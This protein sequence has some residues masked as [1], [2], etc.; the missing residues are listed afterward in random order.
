MWTGYVGLRQVRRENAELQR[1]LSDAQ[2]QLQEQ[3]ALADRSR[4]L[5]QLL[6]L[7]DRTCAR[8]DRR[9]RSSDRGVTPDFR[10]VTIDKGSLQKLKADM[11]VIAPAGVVGRVV[12]T[13]PGAA[14]VQLLIDRNA[15]AGALDERS[16]AQGVVVGTGDALLRMD[17]VSE[18]AD[19]VIGDSIVAS[20]IDGIY[21]KGF[22]IG[23]VEVGGEERRRVQAGAGPAGGRF[24]QPRRCPGRADADASDAMPRG[25]LRKCGRYGSSLRPHWRWRC[26]R[27]WT[28]SSGASWSVDLVLVVVVYTALT[29]GS[30]AGLLAGTFAGLVQDAMS[31][32]ILGMGGL[33]NTIVGFLAGVVGTQFIV[34]HAFSRFVVFALATVLHA[35]IFMGLYQGLGLR[36]FGSPYRAVLEQALGNALVGVLAFQVVEMLPGAVERRRV[37]A[38]AVNR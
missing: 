13:S 11:A 20:G 15:A 34:A 7:R 9:R 16:R 17:Y 24:H 28:G 29:S 37:Q 23:R 35:A 32:G 4:G 19:I 14:K 33:A 8:N 36:D 22:V 18:V 6:A 26:K 5:E 38:Q 21:P 3:R 1:Q 30:V 25:R 2:V 10:T 27:R 31:T 12:V